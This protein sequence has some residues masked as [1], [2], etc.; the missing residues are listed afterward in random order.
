M[1][2]KVSIVCLCALMTLS[3]LSYIGNSSFVNDPTPTDSE[4]EHGLGGLWNPAGPTESATTHIVSPAEMLRNNPAPRPSAVDNSAG[5]PPVGNQQSQGSCTCWAIGYYHAT[6]IENRERPIDMTDPRNQTSPAFLYNIANAGFDT[7]SYMSDVADL[8]ISNGACSMYEKPYSQSDCTSWPTEDWIWVS[9]MKR[10]AASQNWLDASQPYGLDALKAYLAAGNTATTGIFVWGNF[11]NIENFNNTY[12]SSEQYGTNRGG[13]VVTVCGYDD[14]FKTADGSGALRMVNS[15]GT[16]WGDKGYWWLSYAAIQDPDICQSGWMMYL[17]SEV[18]YAPR[19]VAKM[20][21]SHNERGD[22]VRG[23]GLQVNVMEGST[24]LLTKS[25]LSC[26][27]MEDWYGSDAQ[28]HPFPDGRMAFDLSEAF[29]SMNPE[30]EHKFTLFMTN[31]DSLAGT[32]LSYEVINA[33]RWEGDISWDAPLTINPYSTTA[34][35]TWVWPGIFNH[36]PIRVNSDQDLRNRVIGEFWSGTGTGASPFIIPSYYIWGAGQGNCIFIGNTTLDFEITDCYLDEASSPEWSDWHLDSGIYLYSV[37]G[38]SVTYNLAANNLIG[39]YAINS[40]DVLFEDNE[41]TNNGYGI[42]VS[43][44]SQT[45][46]HRN[47]VSQSTDIG[48]CIE[49]SNSTT[50]YHN[51]LYDNAVQAY[52]D[53]GLISWDDGYPS[54]GNYWNDYTG[55]DRFSGP[56]QDEVFSDGIGDTPYINFTGDGGAQDRYPLIAPWGSPPH[57]PTYYTD[58]TWGWNLI[59][60]PLIVANGSVENALSSISGSW[61]V[62]KHYSAGDKADHWKTYRAG[63]QSNDLWSVDNT[64]ALWVHAT[65]NCTLAIAGEAPESTGILLRAGWNMVGYPSRTA[66]TVGDALDRKS[67][68]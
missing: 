48:I 63:G 66:S 54:G 53:N 20:Q 29:D 19:L 40:S 47:L 64:M 30:A 3:P 1:L 21:I 57:E 61:D 8:L 45:S 46:V 51:N 9:G 35:E 12:S 31:L 7:G 26:Y 11:D 65:G 39:V 62:V 34:T 37:S 22:I 2:R 59:S 24:T 23:Q 27:W 38:G 42:I 58:L 25:F 28:Q 49:I 4:S 52:D 10:R 14:E 18:D 50:V 43:A 16:G 32:L 15:W 5:L 44:S 41:L 55:A 17:Q 56:G 13:H 67:V 36:L 60:L 33:E 6:Y 68:V